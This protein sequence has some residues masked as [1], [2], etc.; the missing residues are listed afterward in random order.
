MTSVRKNKDGK[1]Q[2][3][4]VASSVSNVTSTF[5]THPRQPVKNRAVNDKQ[6]RL[7]KVV[8]QTLI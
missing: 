8:S 5:D 4:A 6:T 2:E 3:S 1:D 7:S